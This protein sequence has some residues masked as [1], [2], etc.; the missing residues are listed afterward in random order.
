MARKIIDKDKISWSDDSRFK[1]NYEMIFD[2]NQQDQK[3]SDIKNILKKK[4]DEWKSELEEVKSQAFERGLAQ[5]NKEGFEKALLETDKKLAVLENGF[6]EAVDA[7]Q[8]NQELLKPGL[9]KLVFDISE[10]ILGIPIKNGALRSRLEKDL[11]TLF[12]ELDASSK[13][14]LWIS[15]EDYEF[16]EK[17][18]RQY[19]EKT[20]VVIRVSDRCNPGEYQ[21][22][23]NREKIV[24]DFRNMLNDFKE[25][26]ILPK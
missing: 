6:R 23:T 25:S 19:A 20:G 12:Q 21:L 1:L 8:A 26:L 7:W 24:R 3:S 14:V 4:Q 18:H 2:E 11:S 16:I 9:L 5:G 15:A 17:L 13:P 22:E 10:A